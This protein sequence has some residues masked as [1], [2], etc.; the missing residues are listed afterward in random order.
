MERER[1][2][3]GRMRS[4]PSPKTRFRSRRASQKDYP[5]RAPRCKGGCLITPAVPRFPDPPPLFF[6]PPKKRGGGLVCV[7]CL[8]L[9]TRTRKARP[10]CD[11]E[12]ASAEPG[13]GGSASALESRPV[14]RGWLNPML[15]P[16]FGEGVQ[17]DLGVD[18]IRPGGPGQRVNPALTSDL[19]SPKVD[20]FR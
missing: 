7:D 5:P 12:R 2:A 15:Y 20:N 9:S 1:P 10:G 14:S 6:Y 18:A 3:P 19:F 11:R 13:L 17:V 16:P 8:K 4:R